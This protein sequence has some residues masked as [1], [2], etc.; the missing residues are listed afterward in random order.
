MRSESLYTAV[1]L[2][3]AIALAGTGYVTLVIPTVVQVPTS[4]DA[5]PLSGSPLVGHW[6]E[7][8]DAARYQV[9]I[10]PS[11]LFVTSYD[12]ADICEIEVIRCD[13]YSASGTVQGVI[14][15]DRVNHNNLRHEGCQV[16]VSYKLHD[17]VLE[18]TW[19]GPPALSSRLSHQQLIA[20]REPHSWEP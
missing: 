14:R 1:S 15:L 7:G 17:D 5:R 16:M 12:E 2:L 9:T 19:E 4:H 10:T 8:G 13:Q 20:A 18:L 6:R 3:G 11:V